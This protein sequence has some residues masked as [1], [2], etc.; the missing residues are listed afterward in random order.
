MFGIYIYIFKFWWLWDSSQKTRKEKERRKKKTQNFNLKQ[1]YISDSCY[2][3]LVL[4]WSISKENSNNLWLLLSQEEYYL[5]LFC[6]LFL[7]YIYT[8]RCAYYLIHI[9]K[10][11]QPL[12]SCGTH[13]L[14]FRHA[15]AIVEFCGMCKLYCVT[16]WVTDSKL[17]LT[18]SCN[19]NV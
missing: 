13:S 7:G 16:V 19:Q 9:H 1:K 12:I 15:L 5:L 11:D 10:V 4:F 2:R 3:D 17:L 6:K 8:H 14:F 18:C